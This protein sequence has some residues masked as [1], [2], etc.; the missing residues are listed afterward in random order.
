M[1]EKIQHQRRPNLQTSRQLRTLSLHRQ[2]QVELEP[3]VVIQT[4]SIPIQLIVKNT[5][6]VLTE[7]HMSTLVLQEL[8]GMM[9]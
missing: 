3:C 5:T 4:V 9:T 7:H 2:H 6:S 8:C 1:E